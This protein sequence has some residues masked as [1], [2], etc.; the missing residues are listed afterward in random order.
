MSPEQEDA[1]EVAKLAAM[2][3]SQLRAVDQMTTER[4]SAPANRIDINRFVAQVKGQ[5]AQQTP[6]NVNHTNPFGGMSPYLSEEQVQA[7]VPEPVT[8]FVPPPINNQDLASQMIPLPPNSS[9]VNNSPV[10]T[11]DIEELKE[12]V[13]KIGNTLESLLELIQTTLNQNV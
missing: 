7:M 13:K 12:S 2:V 5:N 3:G 8:N 10:S 4:H 6:Y 11:S 1:L 9:V